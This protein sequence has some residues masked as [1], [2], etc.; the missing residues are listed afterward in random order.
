MSLNLKQMELSGFEPV[1]DL[2]W[3]K[4][5]KIPAPDGVDPGR[6][7]GS[8]VSSVAIDEH[9]VLAIDQP[10]Y[11]SIWERWESFVRL[12]D[13]RTRKWSNEAAWP[14]LNQPRSNFGVFFAM[15]KST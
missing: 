6:C 10:Y 14:S 9:R 12:F 2:K 13:T 3:E 5:G 11:D 4:I 15:V 1:P 7:T 8:F